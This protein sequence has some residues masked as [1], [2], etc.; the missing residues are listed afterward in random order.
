[1][2]ISIPII[3][4]KKFNNSTYAIRIVSEIGEQNWSVKIYKVNPGVDSEALQKAD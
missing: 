2:E 1:M 4:I 3:T